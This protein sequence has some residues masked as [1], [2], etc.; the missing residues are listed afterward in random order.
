VQ[1][2]KLAS[3]QVTGVVQGVG[4]RPFVY[5]LARKY[6]LGG[7]VRNTSGHVEIEV[8]GDDRAIACFLQDLKNNAPP[9]AK[10]EQIRTTCGPPKEYT[11][12]S[13]QDS[14]SEEGRYQPVS[15]D[16]ATCQECQHDIFSPGNRRA[17]YPFTNCT[18]CGP[19]FTIIEDIPYDRPVT[20][21]REFKMCPAC[22]QEYDDPMNRRFHAQ[23][24]ACPLCGPHLE[25][26]DASG[27]AVKCSNVIEE[28]GSLLKCGKILAIKGLGGF[29]LACDATGD[30]TVTTLRERKKRPSKPFAVMM[31]GIEEI[32]SHCFVSPEEKKLLQSPECPIVLLRWKHDS[33]EICNAVAPGLKYLGV[34]I[35][36]TPLHHLLLKE[37]GIPL[38]MTSGNLSEEPIAKD[39][40]EALVRLGGIADYFLIHNR[41]I[42]AAYD[43]SVFIVQNGKPQAVRRARGYAPYPIL[44][45]FK[46]MQVLASG[47]EL[48]NTFCLTRD[49]HA[50]ISQHIGDMENE[51]TLEHYNNTIELYERLFRVIPQRIAYDMHPE[52]LSTKFALE[53]GAEKGIELV[54]VQHH[55]AHIVSCMVENNI[56]DPVIGVAFD[57]TGYGTD[58]SI[59]GG[60]FLVADWGKFSR[61]GHFEYV[62]MP[63]GAAA[64]K[65]PYRMALGYLL[66]LL[67]EEFILNTLPII[68][69]VN[70]AEIEIIRQQIQK[71]INS[72]L[73]SS[74][75]RLMDAISALAGIRGE[76][77]YEAQAVIELEMACPDDN[78][79]IGNECYPFSIIQE[80][81]MRIVKLD[82]FISSVIQDIQDKVP[83][84][85]LSLKT[86]A[87][88]AGIINEM[89]LS[90]SS[91][92]GIKQVA[93]SGGVFQ[94]R[95]LIRLT[96][97]I[98]QK[99]GFNV[100]THHLVPCNDG[101]I[102]LGQAVIANFC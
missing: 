97:D 50:F 61:K 81:D 58:G 53:V 89:C 71:G 69:Q 60:E 29:Q 49:D 95:V 27:G 70:P 2:K 41:G 12:F 7:W 72:P 35:P 68:S 15:P 90:I 74:A 4:F 26:L 91:E 67:P 102:S 39:N 11:A 10:I 34:M 25:L 42:S 32:E 79:I 20:T 62:P 64:V 94:N 14:I 30:S 1:T 75:G 100:L 52:Y 18:N 31:S 19:R 23:P 55:H 83:L 96:M 13:I 38:V 40:D 44:L 65:K 101:G 80:Q 51:E 43:D 17:G 48:K 6:N 73:T 98:L 8:E 24:N 21:M 16:I 59:W 57:G 86:H 33:S 82:K 92:T 9:M 87:T 66:K 47:A 63:G 77:D 36:Y 88:L 37:T 56:K 76:I 84:S 46:S 5:L 85:L 54:P 93:L 3:I 78:G 99:S 45:P 22:Q 28:V